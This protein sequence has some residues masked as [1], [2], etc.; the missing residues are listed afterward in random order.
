ML[1]LLHSSCVTYLPNNSNPLGLSSCVMFSSAQIG[2]FWGLFSPQM[3]IKSCILLLYKLKNDCCT[4]AGFWA[5]LRV[6]YL[7][8][9]NLHLCQIPRISHGR[10][11]HHC[12]L[13]PLGCYRRRNVC[14]LNQLDK[15][16]GNKR[17]TLIR[18]G[19][20]MAALKFLEC[21]IKNNQAEV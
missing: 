14:L 6:S 20:F 5:F 3:M 11:H 8:L 1:S 7:S 19:V 12:Y 9:G 4:L 15:R 2:L 13:L 18:W 17:L 21:Y 10:C 16:K